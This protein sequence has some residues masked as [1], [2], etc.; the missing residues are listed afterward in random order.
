MPEQPDH[1][2]PFDPFRPPS[3]GAHNHG[4][5]SPLPTTSWT[6]HR[7]IFV[8]L[9]RLLRIIQSIHS[10]QSQG[11]EPVFVLRRG[12]MGKHR[13]A[14]FYPSRAM[15]DYDMTTQTHDLGD[16]PMPRSV[17]VTS[18]TRRRDTPR[19]QVPRFTTALDQYPVPD[20]RLFT[21][22]RPT[23]R[24]CVVCS[25]LAPVLPKRIYLVFLLPLINDRVPTTPD[26]A[27]DT[28]KEGSYT[29]G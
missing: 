19:V 6:P 26:P 4:W 24:H 29:S 15:I 5:W 25:T 20:H 8:H 28:Y 10:V 17:P 14:E 11:P 2:G 16:I 7:R 3:E 27:S 12:C 22:L 23:A 18:G 1:P 9:H 13:F 21:G